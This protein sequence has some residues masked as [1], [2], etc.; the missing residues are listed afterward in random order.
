MEMP[1]SSFL[2]VSYSSQ[3]N[4]P[5]II[6]YV[7][8]VTHGLKPAGNGRRPFP[9][10]PV[11]VGGRRPPCDRQSL[12][13]IP[14]FLILCHRDTDIL[15]SSK[16]HTD[17][18][19]V[20]SDQTMELLKVSADIH[21]TSLVASPTQSLVFLGSTLPCIEPPGQP[22]RPCFVCDK[23]FDLSSGQKGEIDLTP[24]YGRSEPKTLLF[25]NV[26]DTAESVTVQLKPGGVFVVEGGSQHLQVYLSVS[27]GTWLSAYGS[28]NYWIP[29][30]W[31][32][33]EMEVRGSSKKFRR[34]RG[35][36]WHGF[37]AWLIALRAPW[38]RNQSYARLKK[39]KKEPPCRLD[40]KRDNFEKSEKPKISERG[41]EDRDGMG[42]RAWLI[43]LS[44]P[45]DRNKRL[46]YATRPYVGEVENA[47]TRDLQ[48][49]SK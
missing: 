22:D 25:R 40:K 23:L 16:H 47:R 27:E 43:A 38:D 39:G 14:R 35:P 12:N 19:P 24:L 5:S 46:A 45:S 34:V 33:T 41:S 30:T 10:L 48:R 9:F 3:M 15:S 8:P 36:N 37:R 26:N 13:A 42:F 17:T 2:Q 32:V 21:N 29:L 7:P 11:F 18:P 20:F 31:T 28:Y 4:I 49:M 1:E 44:A 6:I